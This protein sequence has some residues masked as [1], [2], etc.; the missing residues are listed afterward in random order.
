MGLQL[1]SKTIQREKRYMGFSVNKGKDSTNYATVTVATGYYD[2]FN[3]QQLW[4]TEFEETIYLNH[5]QLTAMLSIKPSQLGLTSAQTNLFS[6][7]DNSIYA[8]IG[9]QLPIKYKLTLTASDAN[10]PISGYLISIL[11]NGVLVNTQ[12][13]ANTD[14]VILE[15]TTLIGATVKIERYGY[16]PYSK[17]Y[18]ALN[19]LV[20][21][22]AVLT[23]ITAPQP[24]P[25]SEPE[26]TPAP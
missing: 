9:G 11:R 22:D 15:G 10:G 7:L 24:D 23:Q 8:V 20:T 21:L 1:D 19:G 5:D 2:T 16:E 25:I 4:V 12:H 26:P 17:S 3:G 13:V 14:P 6:M 18:T